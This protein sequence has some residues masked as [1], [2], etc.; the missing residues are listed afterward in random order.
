MKV[1][2]WITNPEKAGTV[3][4]MILGWICVG[5]GIFGIILPV[6]PGLPFLFA[7]LVIL[8]ARYKWASDCLRWVKRKARRAS[9]L[10][11]QRNRRSNAFNANRRQPVET[12]DQSH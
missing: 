1:L 12:G 9:A 5:I 2:D 4:G 8:S 6:I 7:G 11:S 3:W 10:R